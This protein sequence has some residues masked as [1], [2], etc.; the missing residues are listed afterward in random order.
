MGLDKKDTR[1]SDD[2]EFAKASADW[3]TP[4][5][6]DEGYCECGDCDRWYPSEATAE[7]AKCKVHY[8]EATAPDYV[9]SEYIEIKFY[10][11]IAEAQ[12]WVASQLP[13][14]WASYAVEQH[15]RKART[16]P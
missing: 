6:G 8:S 2:R 1:D 14:W 10:L 16:Q 5:D 4:Q 9:A 3:R 7:A 15:L 13:P 12:E 11:T